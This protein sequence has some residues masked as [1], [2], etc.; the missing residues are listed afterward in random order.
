MWFASIWVFTL[1]LPWELGADFF[2]RHLL[3]GDPASNTLGWR[4]VAGLHTAGKTYLATPKTYELALPSVW[5][6]EV[7]TSSDFN[8]LASARQCYRS[9]ACQCAARL[10]SP[11]LHQKKKA[12]QTIAVTMAGPLCWLL[13]KILHGCHRQR[14]RGVVVL[15]PSPEARWRHAAAS[16]G[17]L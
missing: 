12:V 11:G 3:D 14:R 5:R 10:K 16:L 13:R 8:Q 9:P 6:G 2:V 15:S 4:W 17:I 1:R 7:I